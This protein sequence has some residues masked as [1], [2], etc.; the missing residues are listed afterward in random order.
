MLIKVGIENNYENRSLA[1]VLDYPGC[2]AYGSSETEA[3]VRVPQALIAYKSWLE[4]Y[5]P[6]SWL[7]NLADFDIRLVEVYECHSLNDQ[8]EPAAQGMEVNSWFHHDWLPLNEE[9]IRRSLLVLT[10]AHQDL[11]ELTAALNQEQL[12]RTYAGERWSIRGILFHVADAELYYLNRLSLTPYSR[13]NLSE[14]VWQALQFT[15]QQNTAILPTLA[16]K[17]VVHGL[18]GEFWSPRKILRRACWHALDHCQHV[19]KL[20]TT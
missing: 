18:E 1:W 12:D 17:T 13:Q 3:L 5:T 7:Q 11:Y 20:I 16:G 19:H 9:E 6:E 4:G 8:Y 2:F 15:L 14:D 10:W